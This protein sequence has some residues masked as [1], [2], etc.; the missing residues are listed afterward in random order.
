MVSVPSFGQHTKT[1]M[2]SH[3]QVVT[4][5]YN[6]Y[7]IKPEYKFDNLNVEFE[8]HPLGWFIKVVK[9]GIPEEVIYEH[10]YWD[11]INK[12]YKPLELDYRRGNSSSAKPEI[13]NAI[14]L[15]RFDNYRMNYYYGYDGWYDD[16]IEEFGD[17]KKLSDSLNYA[18]AR[19][20]SAKASD[21]LNDNKGTSDKKKVYKLA[22]GE[23]SM[24]KKQLKNYRRLRHAGIYYFQ[25]VHDLNPGFLTV[26]GSIENKVSNEH[27]TAFLDLKI[28]QNH[29]E[30]MKE[31]RPGL[32]SKSMISTAKNYLESV[33]S[34]AILFVN[35]D[36]DTYPLI[37]VQE[38]LG[39]RKDVLVVNLSLLNTTRYLDFCA[40]YY[41]P[42]NLFP[43]SFTKEELESQELLYIYPGDADS[44]VSLKR[45]FQAI[46]D[47]TNLVELGSSKTRKYHRTL[48]KK[49][50]LQGKDTLLTME[51][52]RGFILR[53]KFIWL[54]MLVENN[55]EKPVYFA[56]SVS[57]NQYTE[58]SGYLEATG[59][60]YK[61]LNDGIKHKSKDPIYGMKAY[62]N[63][64]TKFHWEGHDEIEGLHGEVRLNLMYTT[65]FSQLLMKF[66]KQGKTNESKV[67]L[68]LFEQKIKMYTWSDAYYRTQLIKWYSKL[69]GKEKAREVFVQ[70]IE[71][72]IEYK[73]TVSL[74][75]SEGTLNIINHIIEQNEFEG[76]EELI[77][78][79][80]P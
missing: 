74:D 60:A 15:N 75:R 10:L 62:E 73:S 6:S 8:K 78:R 76:L 32:Y 52:K 14:R 33:D 61:V 17:E 72:L 40:N 66:D 21:L 50:T 23:N 80:N 46:H 12:D 5:F 13:R 22:Y 47:K 48:S 68:E 34:N 79:L 42:N 4:Q 49:I 11:R 27:I 54:D 56:S 77:K 51:L 45:T 39:F 3:K 37:Y 26:V 58:L 18:L 41:N 2:P 1:R 20:Y 69:Y 29:E 70:I 59:F 53:S 28:Y 65:L 55:W 63:V 64:S 16:V 36:N 25:K 7:Q 44:L 38:M 71:K 43:T 57:K 35:G 30:A 67:L 19:A 31:L 24:T 9:V